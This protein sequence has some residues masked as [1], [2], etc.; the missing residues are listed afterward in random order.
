MPFLMSLEAWKMNV[1]LPQAQEE[2]VNHYICGFDKNENYKRLMSNLKSIS[3]DRY[4]CLITQRWK[5][6]LFERVFI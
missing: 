2:G 1:Y 4:F 6:R 3:P 5:C